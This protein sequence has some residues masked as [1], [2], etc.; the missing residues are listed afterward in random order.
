MGKQ[1]K[2]RNQG[3]YK[4]VSIPNN[5]III[6]DNSINNNTQSLSRTPVKANKKSSSHVT[7]STP[8]SVPSSGALWRADQGESYNSIAIRSSSMAS[9]ALHNRWAAKKAEKLKLSNIKNKVKELRTESEQLRTQ[10]RINVEAAA[11]RK[12][13][14]EKKS[15]VVQV[16]KNTSK[17]KKMT[18]QA[19]RL[20][21]KR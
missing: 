15:Q 18:R 21:E 20:I 12:I 1:N 5:N 17:I 8:R 7:N 9:K 10:Q 19:L 14:N 3:K 2:S 11:A 13:E 6:D 16:I 4:P